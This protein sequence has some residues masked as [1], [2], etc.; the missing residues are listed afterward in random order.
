MLSL[1]VPRS[2]ISQQPAGLPACD[3][4]VLAQDQQGQLQSPTWRTVQWRWYVSF[5][6]AAKAL[7]ASWQGAAYLTLPPAVKPPSLLFSKLKT[8]FLQAVCRRTS[9]PATISASPWGT[10]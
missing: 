2:G 7:I 8:G 9:G 4:V 5:N 3:H 10:L 6:T 1:F